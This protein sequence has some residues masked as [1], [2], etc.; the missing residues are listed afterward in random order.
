MNGPSRALLVPLIT[1]LMGALLGAAAMRLVTVQTI[2]PLVSAPSDT[3]FAVNH[4]PIH[5]AVIQALMTP[6]ETTTPFVRAVDVLAFAENDAF[7]LTS[8]LD[9]MT[10][11]RLDA[12]RTR[13]GEN[14]SYTHV[15][16]LP[17]RVHVLDVSECSGG[18]GI[19]RSLLLVRLSEA[20][21]ASLTR[22]RPKTLV[23]FSV[24]QIAL[25]DR[26]N[27]IVS[28]EGEGVVVQGALEGELAPF[29]NGDGRVVLK[30]R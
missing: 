19:F 24:D 15:G 7:E 14:I 5:P 18:S 26:N 27:A 16:V 10:A 6:M 8:Q 22:G 17:G 13:T 11:H 30:L 2:A 1:L 12:K 9:V 21:E 25:G 4:K 29:A 28:V 3:A 23:L 20:S